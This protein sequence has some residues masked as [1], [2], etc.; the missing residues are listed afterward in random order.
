M[1]RKR[2]L[3]EPDQ[4]RQQLLDAATWVFARK[5]F[6]NA[7]ISDIIARA[8]VARGTFYLY[9][10]SKDDVFRLVVETFYNQTIQM[11]ETMGS[12]PP[13]GTG[14]TGLLTGSFLKWLTF[15]D[16]HRDAATVV[17]REAPSIDARFDKAYAGLRRA[18][19]ERLAVRI[20]YVQTLGL[21]SSAI[22][23]EVI[24][25]LQLGMFDGV[26]NAFVLRDPHADLE[27]LAQQLAH[28][29]WNGI[30]PDRKD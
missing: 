19:A 10:K 29:E 23:A 24:A 27:A 22:P 16:A 26:L 3:L 7:S 30:R 5:G 2:V 20:R 11:L 17:L 9:F 1:T 18:A 6:R 8:G 12:V 4:R 28:F 13:V 21:A 14:A 15:V 25:H